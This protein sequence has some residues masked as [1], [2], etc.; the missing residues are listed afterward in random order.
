MRDAWFVVQSHP[1]AERWAEA[2]LA[3]AGYPTYLPLCLVRRRDRATRSMVHLVEAPLFPGYLFVQLA[4]GAP[5]TPIRY[6]QGVRTLV[7]TQAGP[8]MCPEAAVSVLQASEASRRMPTTQEALWAPG[9]ACVARY[10][11]LCGMP[12]VVVSVDGSEAR[13]SF[14][15][16]GAL[17]D[18][19][20][21]T[22]CLAS[23]DET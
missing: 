6:T 9:A 18:V 3:R 20:V 23:R 17:R 14:L 4:I 16:F 1:Q 7:G 10:G 12:G 22:H 19:L 8:T 13:V 21:P 2:N 15:I 5:W 11:A